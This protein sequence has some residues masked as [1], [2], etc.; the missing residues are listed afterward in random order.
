MTKSQDRLQRVEVDVEMCSIA[1]IFCPEAQKFTKLIYNVEKDA[2]E[3]MRRFSA[4]SEL[5]IKELSALRINH[6]FYH[7]SALS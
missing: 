2:A 1:I 3:K 4:K 5:S 6:V 7:F